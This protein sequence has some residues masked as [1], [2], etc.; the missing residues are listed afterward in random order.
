MEHEKFQAIKARIKNH[1]YTSLEP[2]VFEAVAHY[3]VL[4]NDDTAILLQ[5]HNR[6]AD[7]R[8]LH[9]AVG[10]MGLA[11][12]AVKAQPGSTLVT[13]IPPEQKQR[14]L[15]H[16]F[17]V[18]GEMND[19]WIEPLTGHGADLVD[20]CFMDAG[21]HFAVSKVT[22]AV[23]G[24]SREL[25]GESP[26]WVEAWMN[27]ANPEAVDCGAT[28]CNIIVHR[29][30][31]HPVGILCVAVYGHGS[32]KGKV[33]WIRLVAVRP[34]FQGRGIGRKLVNQALSY[35]ISKGAKRAFL[36][37]DSLNANAI[38]LYRSIGF[39]AKADGAQLDMIYK[40]C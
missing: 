4:R 37:A 22:T 25:H 24:Q 17:E 10:D 7:M 3:E 18:Y 16:G 1:P 19:Y 2:V 32:P 12:D 14:F 5:G 36:M 29:E 34:E 6:E 28:D 27:G 40:G 23:R 31:A 35:G 9:F 30:N 11:L 8:E 15:D 26:Q 20:A 38:G 33:V 39:A 13:F 21:E